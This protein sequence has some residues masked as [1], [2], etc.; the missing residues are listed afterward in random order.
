VVALGDVR[1]QPGGIRVRVGGSS[2]V[3]AE[4]VQVAPDGVP[5]VPAAD[6]IAQPAGLAQPGGGTEDVADRDRAPEHRGGSW[7]TA[8]PVRATRSSYQARICGQSVSSAVAA[9]SCS[10][11]MAAC[12]W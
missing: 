1:G 9:S 6:D 12:T 5:A 11:A 8:S 7:R 3:G 10:A 2:E 4:L